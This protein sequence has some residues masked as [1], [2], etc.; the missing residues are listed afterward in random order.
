[1]VYSDYVKQRILHYSSQGYRAYSIAL[2]LDKEGIVV[3]RRGVSKMLGR[4]EETGTITRR[5]GSGRP[6]K[7]TDD[8]R[9]IVEAQMRKDDSFTAVHSALGEWLHNKLNNNFKG[10]KRFGMDFS[11][12][13][14][15]SAN[16]G[17]Q[18]TKQIGLGK[19]ILG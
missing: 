15:L 19:V 18:Q 17:A 6:S 3:S 9:V 14:L 2:K 12:L 7:I 16:Q 13:S 11:W 10:E 8:V 4:F 1:M 5:P